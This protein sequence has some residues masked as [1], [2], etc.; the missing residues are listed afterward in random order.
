MELSVLWDGKR[1]L[2]PEFPL[3]YEVREGHLLPRHLAEAPAVRRVQARRG[4]LPGY[5]RRSLRRSTVRR[6]GEAGEPA[7]WRKNVAQLA[8]P[9]R[10]RRLHDPRIYLQCPHASLPAFPELA[11]ADFQTLRA[12]IPRWADGGSVGASAKRG[13]CRSGGY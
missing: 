5:L 13:L 6:L 7:S 1:P 11:S 3:L 8:Q 2:V 10:L 12:R 9:I 4:S